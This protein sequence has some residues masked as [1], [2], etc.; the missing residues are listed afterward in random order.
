MNYVDQDDGS[1]VL[2]YTFSTPG[3]YTL[4]LRFGDEHI[5]GNTLILSDPI[6]SSIYK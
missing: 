4:S 5:P 1:Y 6:F 3:D 2:K